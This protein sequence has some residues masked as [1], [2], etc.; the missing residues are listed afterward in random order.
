MALPFSVVC[1]PIEEEV[2]REV[3]PQAAGPGRLG[4]SLSAWLLPPVQSL[5][6]VEKGSAEAAD[7]SLGA[8]AGWRKGND[9][10]LQSWEVVSK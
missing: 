1:W 5:C 4:D 10:Y 2:S 7:F 6:L 3:S 8:L 9:A